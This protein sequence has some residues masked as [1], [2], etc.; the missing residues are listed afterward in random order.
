MRLHIY[1]VHGGM[2]NIFKYVKVL[3]EELLKGSII[4]NDVESATPSLKE[5]RTR[6]DE[7][8]NQYQDRDVHCVIVGRVPILDYA[9]VHVVSEVDIYLNEV[10]NSSS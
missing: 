10:S 1:R 2:R 9:K 4:L 8:A 7:I 3:R 6:F 5:A